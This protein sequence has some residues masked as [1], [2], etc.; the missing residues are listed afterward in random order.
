MIIQE[1]GG[2]WSCERCLLGLPYLCLRFCALG[3]RGFVPQVLWA[4]TQP[5]SRWKAGQV[6]LPNLVARN[7]GTS[8]FCAKMWMRTSDTVSHVLPLTVNVVQIEEP[9][10]AHDLVW[11]AL[12]AAEQLKWGR[13]HLTSLSEQDNELFSQA[14]NNRTGNVLRSPNR[15]MWD[16]M[17]GECTEDVSAALTVLLELAAVLRYHLPAG[18]LLQCW[19]SY[20]LSSSLCSSGTFQD[21]LLAEGAS[22]GR[23]YSSSLAR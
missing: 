21:F 3:M 15:G 1:F 10:E 17:L 12:S 14:Q 18:Q 5:Q 9:P 19:R 13:S 4:C 7:M 8:P 16:L 22:P 2:N 6:T 20:F 23:S 11:Q